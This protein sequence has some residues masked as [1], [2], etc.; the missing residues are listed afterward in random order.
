MV[1]TI[2]NHL[3]QSTVF[4][5]GAALLTLA[6][7][8]NRAAVRY[9]LWMAASVKFLVPFAALLALGSQI[10]LFTFAAA[11]H[12]LIGALDAAA[13]PFTQLRDVAPLPVPP[14]RV[15]APAPTSPWL[16]VAAGGWL[17]GMLTVLTVWAVRW[18]RMARLARLAPRIEGGP[19]FDTLRRIE[20]DVR[21]LTLASSAAP[22]EPGVFGI[23]SPVL[24]W[25]EGIAERLSDAQIEAIVAHEVA[26]VQRRDNLMA[27][28]HMVIEAVFWFHP[29]VWWI[30]ARLVDERERACDEDVVRRGSQPH[31]YAE[32]ILKTCQFYV[33]SPLVCVAG[34]TGSNLKKRVEQIMRN[35]AQL[36]VSAMKRL[37][38][39][40]ALIAAIAI[41]VAIGIVTSPTLAAQ[42][43]VP[44]ADAPTFEVAS[45]KLSDGNTSTGGRGTPG[46]FTTHNI[47]LRR[48]IRQAYDIHESQVLGG[49]DWMNSQG[50]DIEAT[51]G[52]RAGDQMRFMLQ[53]L[54]RDRFKLT[55]HKEQREMPIYA[56]VVQRSDGRLGPGLRKT[57]DGE[58]PPRGAPRQG[59]PAA[60]PPASPFDPNA[61]APCGSIIFGP[62]RLLAHGVDIDML[63]RSLAN[64]PA[65]TSF[66]RPVV[67]LT[68][69]EGQHDF[70]FK[71][72]N[73]FG[74]GG[75][76]PGGGPPVAASNPGDE[77]ALFTALQEQLG[78][79]LNAQRVTLDVLVID[80]LE[81]PSEN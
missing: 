59:G 63:S 67:N 70:D 56:L 18:R 36:A 19:V 22:I 60:P 38:I 74:R 27:A 76:P 77:P 71:W 54:L 68:K 33:E 13:Q 21:G 37:L 75:P 81:K 61:S 72:T 48:L 51:T 41:P 57:P 32:S 35:D 10:E 73:E 7:R 66:N 3:W 40:A 46:R 55:F 23:V 39:A 64:L 26:H 9:W 52:G 29:V 47:R 62:G 30:G 17:A 5:A 43:V 24:L 28:I 69:L 1:E 31:V 12:Q 79:K 53:T 16:Y 45:I 49:P 42:I 80:T 4:A 25:P 34:V 44:A 50:F 15:R 65:I 2:A 14:G 6:F 8:R 11:P 78:L 58:C 20:G